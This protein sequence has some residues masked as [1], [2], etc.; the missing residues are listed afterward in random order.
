MQEGASKRKRGRHNDGL[1]KL[2]D[3][4][5][6]TWAKCPHPWHFNFGHAKRHYR[7]SLD[8]HLGRRLKSKSEAETEAER[9]RIAIRDGV[10]NG[11]Q[12]KPT[13]LPPAVKTLD[14]YSRE[15][16]N[17]R[18]GNLKKSTIGFYEANLERYI[19]PQLG[20]L[21]ISGIT[22]DDCKRLAAVLKAKQLKARTVAGVM[23]TLST[24]LSEAVE[25]KHLPANPTLRLGKFLDKIPKSKPDPFN[26]D[27]ASTAVETAREH[28]IRWSG[29]Q[30]A[31]IRVDFWSTFI[32]CGLRTGLRLGELIALQWSDID[33]R[34]RTV[35]VQRNFTHGTLVDSPKNGHN[36]NVDLTPQ[37]ITALRLLRRQLHREFFQH[38]LPRP[39]LIFP[40]TEGTHLDESNVRTVMRAVC[41][42]ADLRRRSPHDLR[43]TFASLLLQT[44]PSPT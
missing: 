19:R 8:K 4:G 16:V 41:D 30:P 26:A 12:P 14:I 33:W 11:E 10:F 38:G 32:L 25:D 36:R 1:R 28:F 29:R 2:C 20:T 3:C 31:R 35:L 34:A 6:R 24:V 13:A 44:G 15:W 40:S 42:K 18:R 9:I 43:H 23:R 5:P 39:E 21:P 22:R 17:Q 37:T 7:F 27:D